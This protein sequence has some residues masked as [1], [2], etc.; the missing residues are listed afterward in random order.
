MPPLMEVA[1]AVVDTHRPSTEPHHPNTEPHHIRHVSL[2]STLKVSARPYRLH[3]T[4]RPA[5]ELVVV[6]VIPQDHLPVM[7]LPRYHSHPQLVH[8]APMVL[9]SK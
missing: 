4:N 7:L 1:E 2:E 8:L 6:E 3:S 9:P 5:L